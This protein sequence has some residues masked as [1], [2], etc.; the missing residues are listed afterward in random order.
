MEEWVLTVRRELKETSAL[1][2]YWCFGIFRKELLDRGVVSVPSLRTIAASWNGRG[3]LDG[4]R[5]IRHRPPP[6]GWYLPS[7]QGEVNSTA[8]MWL[9]AC[10]RRRIDVEV[11]NGISPPRVLVASWAGYPPMLRLAL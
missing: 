5:R 8:L 3:A 9:K 1:G 2:E 7:A 11:L 6:P 10:D 4:R